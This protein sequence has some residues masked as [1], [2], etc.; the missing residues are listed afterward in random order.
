MLSQGLDQMLP[1]GKQL[2][3]ETVA[4]VVEGVRAGAGPRLALER[5]TALAD[6]ARAELR[7]FGDREAARALDLL[8]TYVVS[9]SL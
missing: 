2:S 1:D 8:A 4:A 5:A 6:E 3:A 7:R 9:R